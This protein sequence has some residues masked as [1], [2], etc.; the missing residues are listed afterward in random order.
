MRDKV[1][2]SAAKCIWNRFLRC[3]ATGGTVATVRLRR[4]SGGKSLRIKHLSSHDAKSATRRRLNNGQVEIQ[5]H[6][7]RGIKYLTVHYERVEKKAAKMREGNDVNH[8]P[9]R[10][11]QIIV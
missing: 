7:M 4:L 10:M 6:D 2:Y 1:S 3:A 11:P 8:V 5:M 9:V